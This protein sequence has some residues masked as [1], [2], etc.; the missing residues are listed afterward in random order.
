MTSRKNPVCGANAL[1]CYVSSQ[2]TTV[3]CWSKNMGTMGGEIPGELARGL[4]EVLGTV[5]FFQ[6]RS[7]IIIWSVLHRKDTYAS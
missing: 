3:R 7:Q 5:F 1:K 4:E 2:G 6:K